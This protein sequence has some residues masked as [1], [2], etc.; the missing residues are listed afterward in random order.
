MLCALR[1]AFLFPGGKHVPTVCQSIPQKQSVAGGTTGGAAAGRVLLLPLRRACE[2]VPHK[3]ELTPDDINDP[4]FALALSNLESLCHDCHTKET[5]GATD[6]AAGFC[7]L[8]RADNRFS[9]PPPTHKKRV[10]GNGNRGP[11]RRR[12]R[13][14]SYTPPSP[15]GL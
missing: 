2:E 13:E 14:I 6:I 1:G 8:T 12:T 11:L 7:F 15:K 4:R 10:G 3:V 9:W 5:A